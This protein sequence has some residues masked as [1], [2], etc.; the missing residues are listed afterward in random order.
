MCRPSGTRLINLTLPGTD[1][2]G[3]RLCRPCGTAP[4]QPPQ[5]VFTAIP[6]RIMP[7]EQ[8]ALE[9]RQLRPASS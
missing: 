9:I 2:P 4:M 3:H 8:R 6:S 7:A 1:V 5:Y